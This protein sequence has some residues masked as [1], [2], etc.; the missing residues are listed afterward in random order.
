MSSVALFL[1]AGFALSPPVGATDIDAV[2]Q[3]ADPASAAPPSMAVQYNYYG[4]AGQGTYG[5]AD[6]VRIIQNQPNGEHY[7]WSQGW[8]GWVPWQQVPGVAQAVAKA[9]TPPPPPVL[10]M[11]PAPPALS[12]PTPP[13][14]PPVPPVVA[15]PPAAPKCT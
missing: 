4:S 14:Q 9:N 5:V 12:V 7:L 3:A 6:L 13:A 15:S 11:P 8:S 10:A 1:V 2:A